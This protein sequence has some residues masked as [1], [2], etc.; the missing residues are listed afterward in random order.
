MHRHFF[1]IIS[2]N[3]EY[4]QRHC[5]DL[6]NPL[7]FG[8]RKWVITRKL[9]SSLSKT[10]SLNNIFQELFNDIY[11]VIIIK[12]VLINIYHVRSFKWY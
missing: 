11:Y 9:Q 12:K 2:P 3:L 8:V 5:N 6:N 1:K 10:L 4:V 7:H